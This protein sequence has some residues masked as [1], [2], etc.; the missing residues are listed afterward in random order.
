VL[1]ATT[2][3]NSSTL[4]LET[5]VGVGVATFE[6]F[7]TASRTLTILLS[8]L[9]VVAGIVVVLVSSRSDGEICSFGC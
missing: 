3:S 6:G 5:L 8:F 1:A 4:S 2:Y 9:G 7:R